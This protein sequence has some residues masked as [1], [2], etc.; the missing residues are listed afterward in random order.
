M[1]RWEIYS[2]EEFKHEKDFV[3][4][5]PPSWLS[6]NSRNKNIYKAFATGWKRYYFNC[7]TILH[8]SDHADWNDILTLI[9]KTQPAKIYTLH[10]D[11]SHLKEHLK[12]K[13]EVVMLNSK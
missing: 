9:D 6:R 5:V 3:Y 7:D 13:Y 10:G 8:V 11:G 4:I 1:G 2:R 12:H